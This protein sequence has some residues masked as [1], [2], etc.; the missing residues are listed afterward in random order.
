MDKI[1]WNQK[2]FLVLF[3]FVCICVCGYVCKGCLLVDTE[4][5]LME[6]TVTFWVYS[7]VRHIGI[8]GAQLG[9][10]KVGQTRWI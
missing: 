9:K 1:D 2:C 10:W 5:G 3:I 8:S 7:V 6:F 4:N